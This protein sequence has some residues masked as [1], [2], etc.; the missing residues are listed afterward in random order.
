MGLSL[1]LASLGPLPAAAQNAPAPPSTAPGPV[2]PALP[3]PSGPAGGT[4]PAPSAA[5][6]PDVDPGMQRVAA[7]KEK[8]L[9]RLKAASPSVDDIYLDV[10]GL[11]IASTKDGRIGDTPVSGVIM[12]EAYIQRDRKDEPNRFLCLTGAKGE[13]LFTFFTVR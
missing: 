6:S 2:A 8:A 3:A 10:D 9:G 12:G 13:V 4:Q 1:L 7:C 5:T 11:T